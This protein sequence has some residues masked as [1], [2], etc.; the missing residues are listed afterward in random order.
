MMK[1]PLYELRQAIVGIKSYF[2]YAALFSAAVNIL[3]L[4]PIVYMLQVYDRVVTS[5]SLPTLLTLT[6]I[7]IFLLASLG[8]FE[9][10]R[11]R[12]L[13]NASNLL[14]KSLH[15]RVVD[16]MF[17]RS[18]MTGRGT[19]GVQ[20]VN[21]L[22]GLRQFLTGNGLFAFFDAPWFP[23]YILVMFMFHPW[24][25]VS[26]VI[27]G[28]V[29]V[30]LAYV[31]EKATSKILQAANLDAARNTNRLTGNMRNVEVIEAMGMTDALLQQQIADNNKVL[32]LQS[33]ASR[34]GAALSSTTRA[35]RIIMQSS[36][37]CVGALLVL[38]QD[39][40][41]GVMIAGSLLLGRALAPLDV[42]V[43]TWKNFAV[44]R[45]QFQR[46]E[47]LLQET[48]AIGEQM[49]LPAPSGKL[50][51]EKLVVVPPGSKQVV[52]HH[53]ELSLE[54]GES[55]GIVGP[56]AAGKT[57]LL[58]TLL[59]IWKPAQGCV[60][61]DGVDVAV[62]NRAELGKW[63][64]YLPQDIELFDGTVAQNICRF[65][66]ADPDQIV[67]AAKLADIHEMIL[68]MPDGY[69][70]VIGGNTGMLS[71]GQRQRIGLARAVYGEPRLL[72]LDEPNSNLDDRGEQALVQTLKAMKPKGVTVVV[73]T[74]R[75]SIL[76]CLDKIMVM[77]EGRVLRTDSCQQI[78]S[79]LKN[80]VGAYAQETGQGKGSVA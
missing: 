37:L 80:Q 66:H 25:G 4:V 67:A 54:P 74:H 5:R 14:E 79:S 31:N 77:Q 57:S 65:G 53:V 47:K 42:L 30:G 61:L 50:H 55:L 9:W 68:S 76:F 1:K 19:N 51:A 63:L 60:R 18:L 27:A 72:I 64:G 7:M 45:S 49:K 26:G 40:S 23:I 44:A 48:P 16:S 6:L 8:G 3:M 52:L 15:S 10:I 36:M 11:A 73:A 2:L 21:D 46:L 58:R 62:W 12:I 20:P 24:F 59:G 43:A 33:K 41:P 34:K 71:G 38:R 35:F 75:P 32:A 13:I 39:I 56:S 17:R 28:I 29:I 70:T 69:D 78:I 22:S